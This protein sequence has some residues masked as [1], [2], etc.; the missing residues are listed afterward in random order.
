MFLRVVAIVTALAWLH[1]FIL[2][3]PSVLVLR[4]D[5]LTAFAI[6]L[7]VAVFCF[8]IISAAA[9]SAM[10]PRRHIVLVVLV[11]SCLSAFL[12]IRGLWSH[13]SIGRGWHQSIWHSLSDRTGLAWIYGSLWFVP[14]PFLWA[15]VWLRLH[16]EDKKT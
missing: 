16:H 12:V 7:S 6:N 14:L 13:V 11:A 4:G 3:I 9:Y 15:V 10:R 1:F 5:D 8:G 2:A